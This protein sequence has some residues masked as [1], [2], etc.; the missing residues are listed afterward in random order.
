MFCSHHKL[1]LPDRAR[2]ETYNA[3]MTKILYGPPA[4]TLAVLIN[5]DEA[6]D[7]A[8]PK[9]ILEDISA[10]QAVQTINGL[11]YTIA[12]V[13]AHANANLMFNITLVRD[14]LEQPRE[15]WP[16]IREDEWEE[17]KGEFLENLNTLA[18]LARTLDLTKIVYPAT[19]TE[20]AWT[21]GYN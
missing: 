1:V 12:E 20:P 6:H 9:N 10:R 14:G 11:P 13:L 18:Q 17:L 2:V 5:D 4:D 21:V 15:N 3:Y 8:S 16:K 7:F 19:E